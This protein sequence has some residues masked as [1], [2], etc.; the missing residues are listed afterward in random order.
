MAS[1]GD[2]VTNPHI[3]NETDIDIRASAD[4]VIAGLQQGRHA[5]A[6][7]LLAQERQGERPVV[8]EALDRY[9]AAGARE[10]LAGMRRAGAPEHAETLDRLGDAL[11]AP[12]MPA[13]SWSRDPNVPN[14]LT[15]LSPSQQF[16]VYASIVEARG[17]QAAFDALRRDDHSVLLGLRQENSTL[18][19]HEGRSAGT[20]V[21]DDHMVALHRNATGERSL[22]IAD[23]A[24]TEPTAQYDHHAGSDGTRRYADSMRPSAVSAASPGFESVTRPRKIEGVD[25]NGD[26]IRD[27]GRLEAGTYE[28]IRAWHGGEEPRHRSL[29]PSDAAVAQGQGQVRRDTNGDGYFTTADIGG[30]D[31]LN[32]SMKV[33]IGSSFNTDSA[34]CQTLHP[35][36]FHGFMD[37]AFAGRQDRWQ[38]VLTD[39]TTGLFRDVRVEVQRDQAPQREAPDPQRPDIPDEER[40]PPA[41]RPHLPPEYRRDRPEASRIPETGEDAY[42]ERFFATSERGDLASRRFATHEYSLQPQVQELDRQGRESL[43]FERVMDAANRQAATGPA[44]TQDPQPALVRD[45]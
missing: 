43:T 3:T 14:E 8:Q 27:L 12:R 18:A 37:K 19:S 24:N 20:G 10:T 16:D 30:V 31:A 35:A 23:L 2:A 29:R 33:H 45:V 4:R 42:L 21:Y 7:R 1:A 25:R 44:M 41:Q 34:A 28:M 32:R 22:Y 38:Y 13:F 36:R 11:A 9:V 15:N 40:R 39:T 17:N 5:E 6:L 26:G